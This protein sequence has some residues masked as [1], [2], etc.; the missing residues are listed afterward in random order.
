M[1]VKELKETSGVVSVYENKKT[2]PKI[3]NSLENLIEHLDREMDKVERKMEE[4][5]IVLL[6]K[7]IGGF[8]NE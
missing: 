5:L 4:R 3:D 6:I 2:I 7:N 1:T 8:E